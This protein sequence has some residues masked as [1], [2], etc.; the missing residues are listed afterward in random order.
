MDW[1]DDLEELLRG[2]MPY[3]FMRVDP[4]SGVE[5]RPQID[6]GEFFGDGESMG[7]FHH[8]ADFVREKMKR[9]FM[10]GYAKGALDGL[11]D[12]G[13]DEVMFDKDVSR[14]AAERAWQKWEKE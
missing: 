13:R 8:V 10:E 7:F 11:V 14:I 5:T 4:G 6:E 9:S 12:S 2:R 3:L 1:K